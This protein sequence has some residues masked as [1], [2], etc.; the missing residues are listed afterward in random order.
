MANLVGRT[1][2]IGNVTS[3]VLVAM[4]NMYLSRTL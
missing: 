3:H 2:I 4:Y 1:D